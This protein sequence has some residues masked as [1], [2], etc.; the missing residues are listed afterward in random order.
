VPE[1]P[2]W[3]PALAVDDIAGIPGIS[4]PPSE[5]APLAD[6]DPRSAPAELLPA[7]AEPSPVESLAGGREAGVWE[8]G[9]WEAG[10]CEVGVWEVGVW[11]PPP[12]AFA[13]PEPLGVANGCGTVPGREADGDGAVAGVWDTEVDGVP[14]LDGDADGAGALARGDG[15]TVG[16]ARPGEVALPTGLGLA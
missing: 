16:E 9:A 5:P 15:D 10:V 14:A 8:A 7:P 12:E 6:V 2:P 1:V 3:L 11:E 13:V 4:A